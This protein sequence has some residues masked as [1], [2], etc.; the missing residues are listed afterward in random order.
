MRRDDFDVDSGQ[1]KARVVR[2]GKQTL[3]VRRD[4]DICRAAFNQ[5]L[6]RAFRIEGRFIET[7][8]LS[9]FDP[10]DDQYV[11]PLDCFRFRERVVAV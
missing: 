2:T 1:F 10:V 6:G 8:V 7:R 3:S 5:S 9:G 4:D 11:N